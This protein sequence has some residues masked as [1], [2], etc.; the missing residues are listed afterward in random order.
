MRVDPTMSA[1]TTVTTFRT[2]PT[3]VDPSG[4]GVPHTWQKRARSELASEHDGQVLTGAS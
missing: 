3:A 2:S 4:K 1:K